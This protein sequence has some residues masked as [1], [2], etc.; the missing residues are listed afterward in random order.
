VRQVETPAPPATPAQRP[1]DTERQPFRLTPP[2]P[3]PDRPPPR[4]RIPWFELLRKVFAVDVLACPRCGG[5]LELIASI[6]EP[7]VARR[8]LD[9]LGLGSRAPPLAQVR[10]PD[11]LAGAAEEGPNYHAADPSY[12]D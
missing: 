12:D 4:H 3:P 2:E 10:A 11:D 8:I 7:G 1:G 6:A 9:H 5:R